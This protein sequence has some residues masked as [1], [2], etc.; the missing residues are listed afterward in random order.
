MEDLIRRT[1]AIEVVGRHIG[2]L[3]HSDQSM[4]GVAEVWL[5]EVPTVGSSGWIPVTVR[6]PET[7][8]MM[9]V[10]CRSKKGVSSVNRAYYANGTW[11]GSGSM[12]GV[13]AWMPL[14]EPYR[15]EAD[16]ETD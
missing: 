6:L 4:D 1:D 16:H 8:E 9:L 12:S 14:P 10:S 13:T 2:R 3:H 15:E 5:S 7:D 11:H